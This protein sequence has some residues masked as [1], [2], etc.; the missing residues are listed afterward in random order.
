MN[1]EFGFSFARLHA[2][3]RHFLDQEQDLT[4]LGVCRIIVGICCVWD[5]LHL[6][7]H[8][9]LYYSE[10]G[11]A[12]LADMRRSITLFK[13]IASRRAVTLVFVAQLLL[14]VAL[15]LGLASQVAAALLFV[16]S[17]SRRARNPY[18]T[19][20][21]DAV[22]L[23]STLLL[24][25][26]PCGEVF[27]LEPRLFGHTL[28]PKIVPATAWAVQLL[29]AHFCVIWLR[30]GISKLAHPKW[31]EGTMVFHVM[32]FHNLLWREDWIFFPFQYLTVSK[33]LSWGTIA[34]QLVLPA[35]LWIDETRPYGVILAL[36]LHGGLQLVLNVKHFQVIMMGGAL[37]FAPSS[38]FA[39]L[40]HLG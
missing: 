35:L 13:R 12:R 33:L 21:S 11:F 19:S 1:D 26:T 34:T 38:W 2:A 14:G 31:T 10:D 25:F 6:V 40:H 29:R 18:L 17:V 22:V 24:T 39:W 30:T 36:S 16:I 28:L 15:T 4:P 32:L 8:G 20:G 3:Y 27:S 7:R 23:W 37:L 5:A 9:W